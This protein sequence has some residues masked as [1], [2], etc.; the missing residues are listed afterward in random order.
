MVEPLI[1]NQGVVGSIPILSSMVD[2]YQIIL[3]ISALGLTHVA[4]F[5]FGSLHGAQDPKEEIELLE[6]QVARLTAQVRRL[7]DKK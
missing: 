1:C 3:V 5:Y 4:A 7:M 6:R 2:V